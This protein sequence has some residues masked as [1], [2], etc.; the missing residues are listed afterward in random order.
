MGFQHPKLVHDGEGAKGVCVKRVVAES[1][2][3]YVLMETSPTNWERRLFTF[4][5]I[6][7]CFSH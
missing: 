5:S 3:L 1:V 6:A 7:G 2:F 4:S